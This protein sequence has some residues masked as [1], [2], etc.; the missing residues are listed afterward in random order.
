MLTR[1]AKSRPLKVTSSETL[2]FGIDCLPVSDEKKERK[3]K[4]KCMAD[5]VGLSMTC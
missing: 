1:A 2:A 4:T 5:D 3:K